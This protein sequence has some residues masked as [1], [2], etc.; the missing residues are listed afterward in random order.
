MPL[1]N[2]LTGKDQ[3]PFKDLKWS[4]LEDW[5]GG[6]ATSK[7]IKY[8]EEE[9]V[10]ELKCTPEGSLVARV[11]GTLDYFTEISVKDGKLSSTCTC[12]VGHDCKHG[13]AAVLEYLELLEHGEEIPVIP[14]NDQ[15][16][17]LARQEETEAEKIGAAELDETSLRTL[18]EYLQKLDKTEL[19]EILVTFVRRDSLLDKYI[20]DRQNLASENV[21]DTL[22]EIYS[23]LDKLWE[24]IEQ[25]D[26]S[27]YDGEDLPG[28][29]ELQVRLESLLD[30]GYNK[31]L[32]D[33]GKELM[34]RYEEIAEYDEEGEIGLKVSACMEIIFRAL[35][36]IPLPDYQ[37][38]LY[39]LEIELRDNYSILDEH[40]IWKESFPQEEWKLF[41][42]TL[43]RRI[44]E[45]EKS[46]SPLYTSSW[47][48]DYA[49][50]RLI[51]AFRKAGLYEE[52][53]P[54]S[55]H[56]A[57]KT[58]NYERLV[59]ML[60]EFGK[61][62]EAEEWIY[63]GIKKFR[64]SDPD[65][66]HQLWLILL[67]I[68][69]DEED[70]LFVTALETE[71]FFRTPQ[72][73]SYIGMKDAAKKAG[74]WEKVRVAVH[75]Y[76]TQGELPVSASKVKQELS[77]F[78]G[79]LPKTGLLEMGFEKRINP[80][81]LD[82][83]IKIAIQERDPDQ[84]IRWYEELKK[85]KGDTEKYWKSISESEIAN[86]VRNNY[87]EVAIEIWK[88]LANNL[89]SEAKVNAYEGASAYLRK[90]K[91]TLEDSGKKK[92]W[93]AYLKEIKEVNRRK[94]KLI[95]ILDR[96]GEDRILGE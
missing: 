81:V 53:I 11:K 13:V 54:I 47:R 9:R 78:P 36:R 80:P 48:R 58:G 25:Y 32:L 39:V 22:Q 14:E 7:G 2:K 46:K 1:T 31:E 77:I 68:K 55:R 42:E 92:E 65:N 76:L 60:L 59:R 75:T 5:A 88:K 41:A 16:V 72:M 29:S 45:A 6:T 30:S 21:T 27:A 57:E 44:Q 89:I 12:P 20:R 10:K 51:D 38:L 90:I 83:L 70:W 64:K 93:K 23:E 69:E 15:L 96:L 18:R 67:E 37:K 62:E 17:R 61:K 56:E 26:Y 87:P 3:D 66:A 52:I 24:E 91:E 95:E 35:S 43:Q 19:I 82:L 8:Q 94:R 40:I 50:D 74:I 63:N 79:I 73:D 49:V 28:F 86:A 33:I 85:S 34:E 71:E 84:I 4:D